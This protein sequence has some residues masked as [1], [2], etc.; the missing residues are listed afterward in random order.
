[1]FMHAC[2]QIVLTY[3]QIIYP[4]FRFDSELNAA[5]DETSQERIA[6]EQ[7]SRDKN[8]MKGEMDLLKQELN[9]SHHVLLLGSYD[10]SEKLLA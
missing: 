2:T 10:A 3:Y 8:T 9:V 1:M 7:L 4:L 6:K 5:L